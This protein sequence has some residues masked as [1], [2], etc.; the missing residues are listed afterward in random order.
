[1]KE[2]CEEFIGACALDLEYWIRFKK[3][4]LY[5]I[6]FGFRVVN[7]DALQSPQNWFSIVFHVSTSVHMMFFI[8]VDGFAQPTE[9]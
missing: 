2:K 1:M 8:I 3:F 4:I 5:F 9:L 6:E 7:S